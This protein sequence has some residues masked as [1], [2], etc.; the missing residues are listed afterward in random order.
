MPK[1]QFVDPKEMRK[2]GTLKFKDIP[3][4]A[5][6]K[7][8]ADVKKDFTKADLMGILEDMM[9]IREFE[10]ML[11]EIKV[12][13][14]YAGMN[15]TY[16][17]PSHLSIGQE[18]QAVGQAYYLGVE[19]FIFGTH[20]SH[21]EVIAKAFSAI[22]KLSVKELTEIMEK[23]NGGKLLKVLSQKSKASGKALA[24]EFFIYGMMAELFAKDAGF[25][26]GLGGSMHAFFL[27]FGI[28]P[29][30]A[31]VGAS[32]PVATGAALFKK[33]NSKKGIVVSNAGDGSV[34]CG[35]VF[36][37]LNFAA[38][39]QYNQLWEDG[40]K[41]GL[42]IIFCFN[43]NNYGM[44]GQTCG[45]TMAYGVL[46]RLGAGVSP[47]QLHAERIDGYNVLAVMDAFKRKKALLE[48]GEGPVLL[49]IMTYRQTGH[50]T[51]DVNS[52]RTKEEIEAWKA[53]DSIETFKAQLVK[54]GVATQTEVD[55]LQ[56]EVIERNHRMFFLASDLTLTPYVD[57]KTEE[58]F[59]ENFMFSNSQTPRP[60]AVGHPSC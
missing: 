46:A 28:F 23:E 51:S 60:T 38:M 21:H 40:Y 44:G 14:A 41:G 13:G 16:P 57:M 15:F 33:C 42:P 54:A 4:N 17:G 59:I 5:Y 26:R 20:R 6:Q 29:N 35:P 52:Y 10:T 30:N 25:A 47:T 37:S 53:V 11:T 3:L 9:T 56:A 24:K 32:A 50:S 45:E 12:K 55:G 22:K 19:D 36:E 31:I 1:S 58:R 8:V 39:D 18:A 2:P 49:D 48:K 7:T 43:D 34:G 27:P